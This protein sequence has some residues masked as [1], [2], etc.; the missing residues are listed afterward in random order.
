MRDVPANMMIIRWMKVFV[1]DEVEEMYA[2]CEDRGTCRS[3]SR[4]VPAECEE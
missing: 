3:R 4:H 2:M 1:D